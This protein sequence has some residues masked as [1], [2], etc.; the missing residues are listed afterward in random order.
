MKKVLLATTALVAFAG[1][2][3]AEVKLS[4]YAEIGIAG[5]SGTD[6][7]A[8]TPGT[9]D[10]GMQFWNDIDVTFNL[11]AESESAASSSSALVAAA[12]TSPSVFCGVSSSV[13][14]LPV[15]D[16]P[17][18]DAGLVPASEPLAAESLLL[19][20]ADAP[21]SDD[22]SLAELDAEAPAESAFAMPGDVATITP[23]PKAAA[24]APTR[25]I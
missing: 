3:S 1:A 9:Q 4:G 8:A 14:L 6:F 7:D 23:M 15:A 21:D 25:P 16:E 18:S 24:R 20:P 19:E 22:E 17:S 11:S 12:S 5:G 13:S 10:F 2:A